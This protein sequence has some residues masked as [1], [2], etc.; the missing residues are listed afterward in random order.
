LFNRQEAD[1][2]QCREWQWPL[3]IAILRPS[4]RGEPLVGLV[5]D[6]PDAILQRND[7]MLQRTK[8]HSM[9]GLRQSLAHLRNL[10]TLFERRLAEA[11]SD[12]TSE[13]TTQRSSLREITNFGTNPGKLRLFAHVPKTLTAT[14]ALVVALHGC[15]QTAHA[16]ERGTGWSDLADRYGFV[17]IYPQQQPANNPKSCFSWFLPG[18]TVRDA[19][20]ALSIR[21]MIEKVIVQFGIDRRRVFV[22]GLSAGAAMTSVMLATY[23]EVFAG[24]AILA[25]LPYGSAS[26][27]QEA[28][29]A[30]FNGPVASARALGDRVRG[31]SRHRGPW[32]RISVWHGSADQ[33]VAPSNGES[34]IAQWTN[35]HSLPAQ[36]SGEEQVGRH[37][38]R[39]WNGKNGTPL[40]EAFSV[41]GMGHGEPVAT[42]G[43]NRCGVAG[44]FFLDVGIGAAWQ[45]ARFWKLDSEG[46]AEQTAE[47]KDAARRSLPS[48]YDAE[49]A[50]RSAEAA[51]RLRPTVSPLQPDVVIAAAFRAAGLPPL[52]MQPDGSS[53]VDPDAIIDVALKAAGLSR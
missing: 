24:G 38:R 32:P 51:A 9:A 12:S 14:P 4:Y 5:F 36:S 10:R 43:E 52:P 49:V 25:G 16:Y 2:V 7:R 47:A 44:P 20:E 13:A 8:A 37:I 26:S 19:G 6:A 39:V 41:I 33:V 46:P 18:D 34:I 22:T 27:V 15:T 48:H 30:M 35:V 53:R 17:V 3:R 1:A 28:F 11:G 45:T 50:A 29:D 23:P 40:V 21:Q 31:A 42:T